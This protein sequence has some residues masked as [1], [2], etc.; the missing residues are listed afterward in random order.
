MPQSPVPSGL[1]T[2][3]SEHISLHP[4]DFIWQH[5]WWLIVFDVL[6][7]V[8]LVL[9]L[10]KKSTGP[11]FFDRVMY[12]ALF[13]WP[14]NEALI[15][16]IYWILIAH[17]LCSLRGQARRDLTAKLDWLGPLSITILSVGILVFIIR[18][19]PRSGTFAPPLIEGKKH[20]TP[21]LLLAGAMLCVNLMW[22]L[23]LPYVDLARGKAMF[24]REQDIAIGHYE[25]IVAIMGPLATVALLISFF[26]IFAWTEG[27]VQ[28]RRHLSQSN[29]APPGHLELGFLHARG[30]KLPRPQN[31]STHTTNE[32]ELDLQLPSPA[33]L[34]P[35]RNLATRTLACDVTPD[36]DA[37]L[38][39]GGYRPMRDSTSSITL[40]PRAAK[41][42]EDFAHVAPFSP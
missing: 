39:I 22:F 14:L 3:L 7:I 35:E 9:V 12:N 23:T 4:Q 32:P 37:G 19:S 1:V 5:W 20:S 25:R 33:L 11:R 26:A 2:L 34:N 10:S 41:F 13:T 38:P 16:W 36:L 15:V 6:F 18:L 8:N 21:Q 17:G 40:V 31:P 24:E 27:V 28:A 29:D 30:R 42:T